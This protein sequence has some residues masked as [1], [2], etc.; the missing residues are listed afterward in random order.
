[1]CFNVALVVCAVDICRSTGQ[2]REMTSKQFNRKIGRRVRRLR[3]E[4]GMTQGELSISSGI[5]RSAI[6]S[7]ETGR[8]AMTAY[9]VFLLGKALNLKNMSIMF[10]MPESEVEESEMKIV[11]VPDLNDEQRN[12]VNKILSKS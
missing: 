8:Q 5:T 2:T 3:R 9:Q 10:E 4:N 7:I 6:A 1:M 12:Q 11:G